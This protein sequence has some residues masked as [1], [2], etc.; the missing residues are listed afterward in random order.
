M[1]LRAASPVKTYQFSIRR[2]N[3]TEYAGAES[4]YDIED[5]VTQTMYSAT[6]DKS[7]EV[8]FSATELPDYLKTAV[9]QIGN[10]S[11]NRIPSLSLNHKFDSATSLCVRCLS[12]KNNR[13]SRHCPGLL[14]PAKRN[15]QHHH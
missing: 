8:T 15:S 11:E 9:K 14:I 2:F 1:L 13:E 4:S 7:G 10:N 12:G 3:I 5:V 6:R